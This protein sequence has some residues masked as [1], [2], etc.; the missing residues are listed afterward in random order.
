LHVAGYVGEIG[1]AGEDGGPALELVA[2][3]FAFDDAR[4]REREDEH[5]VGARVEVRASRREADDAQTG[6]GPPRLGVTGRI[7]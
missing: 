6:E 4:A 7:A 3:A 5:L 2:L 1:D